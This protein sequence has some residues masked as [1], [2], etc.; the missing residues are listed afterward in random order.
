MH[1]LNYLDALRSGAMLVVVLWHVTGSWPAVQPLGPTTMSV[2][3]WPMGLSR[4][5]LVLFFMMAGYFGAL[6]HARWGTARFVR[7]R[8][9]RIGVPLLVGLVTIVPLTWLIIHRWSANAAL[10]PE[11]ALHL[12]FI[13]YVL[14]FYAAVLALPHLPGMAWLRRRLVT[15]LRSAVA[16]PVLAAI[17]MALV[18]AAGLL[19]PAPAAVWAIPHPTLVAYYGAFFAFGALVQGS[20]GGMDLV[21]RRLGPNAALALAALVPAV[22]LRTGP[23]AAGPV[24]LVPTARGYLSLAALCLL[25]WASTFTL[26]NLGRRWLAADRP[27]LRYVA[28][29][30]YWIYLM[31]LPLALVLILLIAP[32]GL[33]FPV[34]WLL[35]AALLFSILLGLYELVVRH[36]VVGKVLNG[37]GA[38]RG[39]GRGRP[40][41]GRV[42]EGASG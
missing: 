28:D 21:G 26:C 38:P 8:L 30:S 16:V 40:G 35:V 10:F 13:Y 1:R 5:S 31:H 2:I 33:P 20:S 24:W 22:L 25:A 12:W 4:W 14:L 32:L 19:P 18:L 6:L 9:L 23:L 3:Q 36:S 11:G 29:S 37:P 17:T 42:P 41:N 39:W 7:D 34:A 15:L 27:A